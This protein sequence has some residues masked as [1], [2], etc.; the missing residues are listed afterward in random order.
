MMEFG[1]TGNQYVMGVYLG[2]KVHMIHKFEMH[3][4]MAIER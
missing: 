1:Y 4:T 2:D 3:E